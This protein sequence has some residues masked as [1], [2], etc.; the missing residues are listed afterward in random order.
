MPRSG[1]QPAEFGRTDGPTHMAGFLFALD[2]NL[3]GSAT[4]WL[5]IQLR[6]ASPE[7]SPPPPIMVVVA[8]TTTPIPAGASPSAATASPVSSPTSTAIALP[9]LS[10][11]PPIVQKPTPEPTSSPPVASGLTLPPC[12]G[13]DRHRHFPQ[14]FHQHKHG[15]SGARI[16]RDSGSERTNRLCG[17]V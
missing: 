10:P 12:T 1:N 16:H 2:D 15:Y 17:T 3:R 9:S 7:A 14:Y 13:S 4:G 8:P 11:T 5:W 6:P